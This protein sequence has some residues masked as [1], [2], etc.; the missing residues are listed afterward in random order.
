LFLRKE[1]DSLE[2]KGGGYF[3]IYEIR[4]GKITTLGE[5]WGIPVQNRYIPEM[6][7]FNF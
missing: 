4:D 5:A 6:R 1:E 7:W 2:R 3:F